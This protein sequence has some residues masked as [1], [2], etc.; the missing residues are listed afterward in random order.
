MTY[1]EKKKPYSVAHAFAGKQ[2]SKKYVETVKRNEA[3]LD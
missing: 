3:E 2:G 1:I